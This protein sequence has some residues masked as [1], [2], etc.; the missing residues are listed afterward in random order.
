MGVSERTSLTVSSSRDA[1]G[2]EGGRWVYAGTDCG[3]RIKDSLSFS[4]KSCTVGGSFFSGMIRRRLW[5]SLLLYC[6][7]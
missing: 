1:G 3:R 6:S 5:K 7:S 4:E 2:C